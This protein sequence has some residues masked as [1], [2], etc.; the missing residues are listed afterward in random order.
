MYRRTS[1]G[2]QFYTEPELDSLRVAA[3][4]S[5]VSTARFI[6]EAALCAAE[7]IAEAARIGGRI[8]RAIPESLKKQKKRRYDLQD[9]PQWQDD[10][11]AWRQ[12]REAQGKPV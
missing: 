4:L 3:K 1:K 5:K 6:R 12:A 9:K 11:A 7:Q 10:A 8:V 2:Q